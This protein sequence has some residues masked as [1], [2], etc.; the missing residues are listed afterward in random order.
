MAFK[1]Y[2]LLFV[3]LFGCLVVLNAQGEKVV[4]E[5]NLPSYMIIVA[6]K[7]TPPTVGQI[8][9]NRFICR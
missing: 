7:Q 5:E 6:A 9:A 4:R 3:T 1:G 8:A 2:G